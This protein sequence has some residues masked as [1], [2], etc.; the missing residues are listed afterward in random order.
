MEHQS[1][2][3]IV[4]TVNCNQS[5]GRKPK[6]RKGQGP[7]VSRTVQN[8]QYEIPPLQGVYRLGRWCWQAR[9]KELILFTW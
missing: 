4:P 6:P 1:A 7:T 3:I 2:S 8:I 5:D 9:K